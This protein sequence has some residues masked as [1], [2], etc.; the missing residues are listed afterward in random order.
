[1]SS[2]ASGMAIYVDGQRAATRIIRDALTRTIQGGGAH[3]L[4]LAQ[5]FR[6]RGLKGGKIDELRVYGRELMP[7]EVPALVAPGDAAVAHQ[8]ARL[9]HVANDGERRKRLA[10]L[11]E[12]RR[13]L[14]RVRDAQREIMVM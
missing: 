4:T 6:D 7:G 5:R 9:R 11:S 1:G 13:E 2:R 10:A 14:G 12:A 3:S 8:A